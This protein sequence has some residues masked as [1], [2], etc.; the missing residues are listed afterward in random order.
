[1]SRPR[2]RRTSRPSRA[3]PPRREQPPSDPAPAFEPPPETTPESASPR[4]AELQAWIAW[5]LLALLVVTRAGLVT[6]PS[7]WGWGINLLRFLPQAPGWT[8]W[9][10]SAAAL[11]LAP[12]GARHSRTRFRMP[13]AALLGGVAVGAIVLLVVLLPDRAQLTGDM[14]LRHIASATATSGLATL[15]PQG[16][17]LDLLL[18]D[19]FARWVRETLGIAPGLAA[20]ALGAIEA[21]LLALLAFRFTRWLALEGAAAVA[22]FAILVSGGGL[23]LFAGYDKAFAELTLL[24]LALGSFGLEAVR[25]GSGLTRALLALGLALGFHRLSLALIPAGVAC[26]VL[27]FARHGG[28]G[29][30]RR[31]GPWIAAAI[32]AIALALVARKLGGAIGAV[33][34]GN[35]LVGPGERGAADLFSMRRIADLKN[36][37]LFLAPL[38]PLL[39]L[40]PAAARG[41]RSE[42]LFL[43]ALLAPLALFVPLFRP[44][45]G[46]FRD[47]DALAPTAMALNLVLA[48]TLA[49]LPVLRE[50]GAL[51]LAIALGAFAPTAQALLLHHDLPASLERARAYSSE[52]PARPAGERA[53]TWDWVGLRSIDQGLPEQAAAAF[54]QAAEAAPSPKILREWATAER[55]SGRPERARAIYARLVERK[56]DDLAGWIEYAG[57]S[58]ALGDTTAARAAA[59]RA[60]ELSPGEPRAIFLLDAIGR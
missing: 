40:T 47:W 10:L 26:L 58:L 35:F 60:L 37:A 42:V 46:L 54:E 30:W 34:A 24:T 6:V 19:T 1:M 8:L 9:G 29:R 15:Y 48:W 33:D 36:A 41:A 31:P 38:A 16:M 27:W 3:A 23:T 56:P 52:P 39:A 22:G 5:G 45:Q 21:A 43:A 44:P 57:L 2:R 49:R 20:R 59:T 25:R 13:P 51:A 14:L 50:R 55:L 11:V 18:H 53:T 17:P 28:E 7:M 32:P 12:F 4:R